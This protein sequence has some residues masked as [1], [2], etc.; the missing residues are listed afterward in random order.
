MGIVSVHQGHHCEIELTSDTT[1]QGIWSMTDRL[2]MPEGAPFSVMTGYGNYHETYERT[3][4][5]W[6]IK[7]LRLTRIRVEAS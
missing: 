3:G 5:T 4:A 7:T 2:Y 1:A 6:K